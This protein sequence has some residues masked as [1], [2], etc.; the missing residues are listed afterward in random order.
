[1]ETAEYDD[2]GNLLRRHIPGG[3]VDQRVAMIEGRQHRI[4][5]RFSTLPFLTPFNSKNHRNSSVSAALRPP[6]WVH[7]L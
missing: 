3:A 1:M 7:R 2:A 6:N 5:Y 4:R